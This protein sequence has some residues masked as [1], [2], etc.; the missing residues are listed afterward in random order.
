[1]GLLAVRGFN[2][3]MLCTLRVVEEDPDAEPHLPRADGQVLPDLRPDIAQEPLL[4]GGH[5]C[6]RGAPTG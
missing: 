6:G 5:I 3:E 4:N 2:P 1:M